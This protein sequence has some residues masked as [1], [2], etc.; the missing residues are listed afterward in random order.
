M[1]EEWSEPKPLEVWLR[2]GWDSQLIEQNAKKSWNPVVGWLYEVPVVRTSR[3]VKIEDIDERISQCEQAV[4]Q[5]RKA[6]EP[7]DD[8]LLESCS[9][10]E[11]PPKKSSG[12]DEAKALAAQ[13][14]KEASATAQFNKRTQALATRVV[15]I[16][17]KPLDETLKAMLLANKCQQ[18]FPPALASEIKQSCEALDGSM[19]WAEG[20]L[21]SATQAASSGQRLPE[22]EGNFKSVQ[23]AISENKKV[24]Q[25]FNAVVR[26]L[27]LK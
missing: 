24:L 5:K 4:R 7:A 22:F 14:R 17:K 19:K 21:K 9:D 16:A 11:P 20:V 12:K 27:K 18:D 15:A 25:K 2:Q 3:Q 26:S 23:L 10:D 13:Q 1:A 6:G 8:A